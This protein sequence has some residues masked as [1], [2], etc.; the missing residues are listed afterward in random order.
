MNEGYI[1]TEPIPKII[2]FLLIG[3]IAFLVIG[4]YYYHYEKD[5]IDT[6][7]L[8]EVGNKYCKELDPNNL[9]YTVFDNNGFSCYSN[10]SNVFLFPKEALNEC[11][12]KRGIFR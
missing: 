5:G 8:E 12:L 7:C 9:L 6:R 11:T 10:P 4:Y 1:N 2:W 3:F